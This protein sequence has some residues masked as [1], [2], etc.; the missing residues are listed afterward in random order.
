MELDALLRSLEATSIATA[1]RENESLFP[2]VESFHVLAITLV[3]GS[4]AIVDLRLIGLAS[5]E[6]AAGRLASEVLRCTWAAFAVA[7]ITGALL[8]AS[9]A[10]NYAHNAPLPDP[11]WDQHG[12]LSLVCRPRYRAL[13]NPASSGPFAGEDCGRCFPRPLDRSGRFRPLGRIQLAPHSF[14]WVIDRRYFQRTLIET[15]Q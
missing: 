8:F 14:G 2:W 3:I 9:N 13:G 12:D 6:R 4:I 5:R 11:G 7:A 15:R 1:I 10:F